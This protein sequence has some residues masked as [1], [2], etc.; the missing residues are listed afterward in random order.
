MKAQISAINKL[1]IRIAYEVKTKLNKNIILI[2]QNQ[3]LN[4]KIDEIL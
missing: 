4:S 3:V 1:K 2:T